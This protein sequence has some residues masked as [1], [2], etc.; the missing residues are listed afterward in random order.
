MR[1]T[2]HGT[3]SVQFFSRQVEAE[4]LALPTGLLARFLRYAERL[5]SFGPNLGMPHVR[6]MGRGLF[7]LRLTGR[8]G[9]ARV[10]FCLL[11][12]RR[13]IMLHQFVKKTDKTPSRELEIAYKRMRQ[14]KHV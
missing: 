1:Y 11:S 12:D 2:A 13:I 4:L 10:F 7:E 9:I 8:E 6:S 3:W 5:E 14:T